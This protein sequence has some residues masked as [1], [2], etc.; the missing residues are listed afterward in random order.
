MRIRLL[1]VALSLGMALGVL[2]AQPA[3]FTSLTAIHTLTNEQAS[4]HLPV[5]FQATI[6]Y[7]RPYERTMF[8]Q[9]G[10]TAI[11]VQA[12]TALKVAPG[13]LILVRGTTHE[14]FRPFVL[15]SDIRLLGR[16]T[17]PQAVPATFKDLIQA[18]YDCRL[19]TVRALVRTADVLNVSARNAS[20]QM[21][22][23]GGDI[24]ATVDT[25]DAS[26]LRNLLDS[27][28]E[29]TGVASGRFDG[30]MQQTGVLIH[31]TSIADIKILKGAAASPW[32]IPV[33][34]MDQILHDYNVDNRNPRVR[35]EG[36][37]TYYQPGSAAVLQSGSKSLWIITQERNDLVI[38][39]VAE[40]TGIPDVHDGFLTLTRGEI[41]DKG[42][43]APVTP[44]ASTWAD[45]SQSRHLFDLVSSQGK[46]VMEA[47]EAAQDEYVMVSEGHLFSAIVRHPTATYSSIAPPALP[48]MKEIPVGSTVQVVGVCILDD[49]NPF[50]ANVPFNLMMRSADDIQVIARPSW[51]SVANLVKVVTVLLL[52]VLAVSGWGW[53][54]KRKVH[55]QT[56]VLASRVEAEAAME[57]RN[58]QIEQR[59]SRILED[60]NGSLPLAEVLEEITALVSFHL[61]E[62]PCWCEINDGARLGHF[63]GNSGSYR[64][65][66]EEIPGRSGAALGT[67][68]AALDPREE[69]LGDERHALY[70]GAR[71]STL[72]IETRRLYSDL[73]HR[74]EF[75][76]L[77][78]IRNRFSLD[79]E[80]ERRITIAREKATIFGLI[81]IDL[82]EFKQVNDQYGHR[83]GD[84][85]LQEVADRMSRQLRAGDLLARLGGDE[86]AALVPMART[87]ADV[88]EIAVRLEN[89][90]ATPFQVEGY[91]LSGSASIGIALYPEDGSTKDSLLSAAD[92][93]MYV[94]KYTRHERRDEVEPGGQASRRTSLES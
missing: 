77:T 5:E 74:S 70:V 75:D 43:Q 14:S 13:D 92:A 55:R 32:S 1:A 25:D 91:S 51:L 80:L 19:V 73:V 54:L 72:A 86:F 41:H 30:K 48:P 21:M 68:Y 7:Y 8:V 23:E 57:R 90:F 53:T 93:A 39:D 18:R 83:V 11:Y 89:C 29:V 26:T 34:P 79:K 22:A 94:T 52:V 49:A 40:A 85:Y 50:D 81:Y 47:R 84:L 37:I 60:I 36:T 58:A 46:V 15:S 10:D 88:K 16:G 78:D 31:V 66:L 33:T 67:L 62:A 63:P 71:L 27:E 64:V 35:I 69:Q 44:R 28:V 42:F 76:L 2:S 38:G 45:L 65:V 4:Q 61:N 3:Q 24:N 59:R 17:M 9:D 82:D 87:R 56:A 20:M 6:T 12:P